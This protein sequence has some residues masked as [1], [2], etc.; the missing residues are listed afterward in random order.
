MFEFAFLS[1]LG[2]GV[3]AVSDVALAA[4]GL[5]LLGTVLL[6]TSGENCRYEQATAIGCILAA[7][8][9][10]A[11]HPLVIIPVVA[12]WIGAYLC[13]SRGLEIRRLA[14]AAEAER[15]E[16]RLRAAKARRALDEMGL[17]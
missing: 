10:I 12:C 11:A 13:I 14:T 2:I 8:S 16:A 9:P 1:L 6:L 4:V 17:A 7:A 15:L 5:I 3:T